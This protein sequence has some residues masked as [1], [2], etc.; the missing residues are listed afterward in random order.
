[1]LLRLE[2]KETDAQQL[3]FFRIAFSIFCIFQ[4]FAVY[5]NLFEL[6]GIN[7]LINPE[8]ADAF[9][10]NVFFHPNI[11]HFY[12]YFNTILT[13][14]QFTNSVFFSYLLCLM[15][16]LIG[17][18]TRLMA[19]FAWVLH[20]VLMNS[21]LHFSYGVEQFTKLGC[22]TASSF[23]QTDSIP[24]TTGRAPSRPRA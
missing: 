7:G 17:V 11:Q 19:I 24:L 8:I 15:G 16:M 9:L 14:D 20:L 5:Q 3:S 2:A 10:V 4:A 22:F 6:Y 18:K 21:A 23:Q 13:P 1:M 12:A